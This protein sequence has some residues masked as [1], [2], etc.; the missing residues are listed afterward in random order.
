MNQFKDELTDFDVIIHRIFDFDVDEVIQKCVELFSNNLLSAHLLDILYLNGKLQLNKHE[1]TDQTMNNIDNSIL[2]HEKHLTKY[3]LQL[4]SAAWSTSSL[5]LNQ[6]AF[7]YLIK[8][9]NIDNS[10]IEL[11][12]TYLERLSLTYISEKRQTKYSI[13]RFSLVCMI[14]RFRSD[15]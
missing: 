1:M 14:W 10:G 11:I 2:M 4:L 8:C 13:W 9:T 3:A 5:S 7:D 15:E 12:E 6:T